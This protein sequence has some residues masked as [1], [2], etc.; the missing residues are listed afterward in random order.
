MT[1][2]HSIFISYRRS[3]SSDIVGRIYD[4]LISH[5][6][7]SSVFK[8]VDSIPYG[9]DYREHIRHWVNRCQVMLVIIGPDWLE[10]KGQDGQRR[11]DDP[12][13]WVRLEIEMALARGIPIVPLLINNASLPSSGVLPTSLQQLAYQNNAKA[14]NDP[15][16]HHDLARLVQ[17]LDHK[18][19]FKSEQNVSTNFSLQGKSIK[20]PKRV[21]RFAVFKA[22]ELEK[23]LSALFEDYEALSKQ[24]RY[25]NNDVEKGKLSRQKS[26][27]E[28]E[29][30]EVQT[31]LDA[32]EK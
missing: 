24:I 28:Q 8:D 30:E 22:N 13:D 26:A 32:L 11:L 14:R 18:I 12:E 5:Y 7:Q 29:I 31:E 19:G 17:D 21:N 6:G 1:P 27:L 9:V 10:T 2:E 16:F 25:S 4:K 23:R 3:D 20:N 15:D